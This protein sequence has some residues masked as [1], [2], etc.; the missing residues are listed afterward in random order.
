MKSTSK[1]SPS[2]SSP[3]KLERVLGLTSVNNTSFTSSPTGDIFYAAGCFAV[4][5]NPDDNKQKFF[6][7]ASKPISSIAISNDGK[8]LAVGERGHNPSILVY[9]VTNETCLTTLINHHKHGVGCL[10]FSPD[11][12]YLVSVGFK[13]DKQLLVWQWDVSRKLSTQKVGNKVHAISYH[14]SGDYFVTAGDRHLKWWYVNEVL[15]GEAI[16]VEGKAAS[17]LEDQ[18]MSVFVDVVCGSGALDHLTYCTTS[19]GVLSVFNEER[20]VA[21]NIQLQ[22]PSS[23]CL[24]LIHEPGTS[25]LLIVG[26]ADGG[27]QC[28]TPASL[29]LLARLPPPAPLPKQHPGDSVSYA[30]AVALRKVPGSKTSPAPKLSVIYADHSLFVW[31]ITDLYKVAKFRS[32]QFHHGCVWDLHFIEDNKS[33]RKLPPGTFVTCSSDNSIKFW[34][35][36]PRAQRESKFKSVYSREMLHNVDLI[37]ESGSDV[38]NRSAIAHSIASTISSFTINMQSADGRDQSTLTAGDISRCVIDSEFPSRPQHPDAPR[39][40]SVHPFGRELA[41]GSKT[42]RIRIF[43]LQTMQQTL[44]SE[45]H[46][47]EILS[48]NY[49]PALVSADQK[50]WFV[51]NE[52]DETLPDDDSA[53]VLLA[54]AGRDRLVH[55]FNASEHYSHLHTLDHHS[56]S[57]TIVKFT[58]DGKKLISCGGDKNMVF[59]HVNGPDIH[60]FKSIATPNGT[61]N[62]LAVDTSNKFAVTSGQDKRLN[63]WNL[64]T[65][66]HMRAYKSESTQE[67]YKSD[68]DP[69][70]TYIATCS[71]DKSVSIYDFFS[72]DLVTQVTGHS[73]LVTGVRF[74]PDGRYLMTIGGDGCIMMW[75]VSDVLV[76]GMQDR[77]MEMLSRAQKQSNKAVLRAS[78]ELQRPA[79]TGGLPV[80]PPPTAAVVGAAAAPAGAPFMPP[81][82]PTAAEEKRPA[83]ALGTVSSAG[84][85]KWGSK[86]EADGGY[87]LF[88]RKIVPVAHNVN[89]FTVEL[90]DSVL[91]RDA[92]PEKAKAP[93]A[94]SP[95]KLAATFER[96][97]VVLSALSDDE[98]AP[99]AKS[100]ANAD[101]DDDSDEDG[102][103]L[104]KPT[105]EAEYESDF[106]KEEGAADSSNNDTTHSSPLKGSSI[107]S[108]SEVDADELLNKAQ[109]RVKEL[110]RSSEQMENWLA[111]MVSIYDVPCLVLIVCTAVEKRV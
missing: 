80:V 94:A 15:E 59:N 40:M 76:K 41:V 10:A 67:L 93:P 102:S 109:G 17:I 88:G 38:A 11:N 90:S 2:P 86:S 33:D 98:R 83:T 6:F 52:D 110:E 22:S 56:S 5:Y 51:K 79:T 34:N 48:L 60:K 81:A 14:D 74:S 27:V 87:E 18:R 104:F 78:Q 99:P 58:S 29:D 46:A 100:G 73:E 30:A 91:I 63:V 62:G 8:Y 92:T 55:V 84:H 26:C 111:N 42:G 28:F 77:L 37:D 4:K 70:G 25:G 65:G 68:L 36:D 108:Q 1:N 64:V 89:K 107:K 19:T 21:K 7:K 103:Y 75:K 66:K 95:N 47:A 61:I 85:K 43:D 72:G 71:F 69:S 23:Y 32:F 96:D 106:E 45:A 31:D 105:A 16:A 39:S 101:S 97:D 9:D 49:S 44:C 50:Y 13:H 57:V 20:L 12:R 3:L 35:P 53:L 24:E 82:P 54:S